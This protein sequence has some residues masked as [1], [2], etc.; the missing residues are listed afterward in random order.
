VLALWARDRG[1]RLV[2]AVTGKELHR[3][4][5]DPGHGMAMHFSPSG[6]QLATLNYSTSGGSNSLRLWDTVTGKEVARRDLD[7]PGQFIFSPDGRLL[8]GSDMK[9][10]LPPGV[11]KRTFWVWDVA[12]RKEWTIA[13]PTRALVYS[14]AW[15]RDGRVL[16]VGAADGNIYLLEWASGQVRRRL[17]GHTSYIP[18]LAFSPDGKA[19]ASGSADCTALVWAIHG[20]GGQPMQPLTAARLAGLWKD[21]A[22]EDAARAEEALRALA[23]GAAQAVPFVQQR[24]RPIVGVDARVV[25]RLI[26]GLDSDQFEQ[27]QKATQELRRLGEGAVPAL[28]QALR[29]KLGLEPRKRIERLVKE[30]EDKGSPTQLRA[31]RAVEMLERAATPAARHTLLVL[32]GG[33]RGARLTEEAQASLRRLTGRR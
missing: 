29:G 11:E 14:L 16:A 13:V 6:R 27:R 8:V 26:A 23:A 2:D 33:A 10:I 15:S 31:I 19:L 12:G 5:C 7:S 22:R 28:R 20:H 4:P 1:L 30:L 25:D 21:L 32:A 18:S 24:L 9:S 3:L 17:V